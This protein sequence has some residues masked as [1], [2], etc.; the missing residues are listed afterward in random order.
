MYRYFQEADDKELFFSII[1]WL[2]K[3]T[4]NDFIN[5]KKMIIYFKTALRDQI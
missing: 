4:L 5:D 1:Y 2:G 3:R